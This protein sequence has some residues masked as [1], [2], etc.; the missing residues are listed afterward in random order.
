MA[1]AQIQLIL[2]G[3]ELMRGDT[4]DSNSAMIAQALADVGIDVHLKTTVGD[5]RDGLGAVMRKAF[6]AADVVIVNGGLGP[7]QDDLTAEVMAGVCGVALTSH[8]GAVAHVEAWCAKRGFEANESNLKQAIL[9]ANC[10]LIDNPSGSAVGFAVTH[11]QCLVMATPGVPSELR[12]ML[13]EVCARAAARV[14]STARDVLRL[15]TF[16]LG[17]SSIEELLRPHRDAWPSTVTL[18][19]R[20]GMPQLELKLSVSD[21]SALGDRERCHELLKTLF[22]DHII[23]YANDSLAGVLQA[24]LKAQNKRLTTAESC[25]G[26]LIASMITREPGSSAVFEAGYVTYGNRAKRECLGVSE[27]D[28]SAYGA[29]SEP[30]ARAMLMGALTRSHADIGI[31][32]TGIAGPDGGTI[33]KPVGTVWLAWGSPANVH[34][35]KLVIPFD[36][37]VFQSVVAAIGLDLVR[38]QLLDLPPLPQ[39]AERYRR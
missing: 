17:E 38:R 28:L 3:D 18:G 31:A 13:A 27:Q 29:V 15:Q 11:N 24:L 35:M 8:P 34:T 9:P 4:I 37:Q 25:T 30:V 19:F 1:A 6:S 36:R 2:T 32:V 5:D 7:T 39:F 33:D 22:G 10:D 12:G 26:G 23:G 16:G 14:G 20:A 21:A